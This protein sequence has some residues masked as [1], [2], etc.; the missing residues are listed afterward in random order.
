VKTP[1]GDGG[2][3]TAKKVAPVIAAR[4]GRTRVAERRGRD[5][6][7]AIGWTVQRPRPRHARAATPEARAAFRRTLPRRSPGKPVAIPV[8]PSRCLAPTGTASG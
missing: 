5:A 8:Q 7:R 1:P 4:L 6:L 3:W 2:V